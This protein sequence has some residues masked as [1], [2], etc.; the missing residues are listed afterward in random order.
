M[1]PGTSAAS[2]RFPV[3]TAATKAERDETESPPRLAVRVMY[4]ESVGLI[5][6]LKTAL[7]RAGPREP[8][9]ERQEM[10]RPVTVNRAVSHS[11]LG[12]CDTFVLTGSGELLP[13]RELS[14]AREN[15]QP[16]NSGG[17]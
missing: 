5:L 10:R 13:N 11:L 7:P 14:D 8:P 16:I 4:S 2:A 9:S 3:I 6:L 17:Q 12:S 1:T 15:V